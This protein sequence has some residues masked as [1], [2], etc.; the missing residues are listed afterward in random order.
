LA[1]YEFVK[2]EYPQ[3]IGAEDIL[4]AID[5]RNRP[6]LF[7]PPLPF[8]VARNSLQEGKILP[9][10]RDRFFWHRMK[11]VILPLVGKS[12]VSILLQKI[13]HKTQGTWELN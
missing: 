5:E 2:R 12:T 8:Y 3:V 11:S 7:N 9:G 10:F 13:C 1:P 4:G 6:L